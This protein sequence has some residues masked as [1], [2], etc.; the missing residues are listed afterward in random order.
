[1]TRQYGPGDDASR[2]ER[3]ASLL[4]ETS[5]KVTGSDETSEND[6]L[7]SRDAARVLLGRLLFAL[8][9][10][11]HEAVR[12]AARD[13]A[14]FD[15]VLLRTPQ[16]PG[17][18]LVRFQ[19]IVRGRG[20]LTLPDRA[21]QRKVGLVDQMSQFSSHDLLRQWDDL[22][23]GTAQ[24]MLDELDRGRHFDTLLALPQEPEDE[25]VSL[26]RPQLAE[27][28]ER[29][30]EQ[31]GGRIEDYVS[32]LLDLRV[33]D[34][35]VGS[36]QRLRT[37]A[38]EI[39]LEV[40]YVGVTGQRRPPHCY[41]AKVLDTL[42]RTRQQ[43]TPAQLDAFEASLAPALADV[44]H[45]C[46]FGVGPENIHTKLSK[47]SYWLD[48][49]YLSRSELTRYADLFCLDVNILWGILDERLDWPKALTIIADRL[50][51]SFPDP[52]TVLFGRHESLYDKNSYVAELHERVRRPAEELLEWMW[53]ATEEDGERAIKMLPGLRQSLVDDARKVQAT[54]DWVYAWAHLLEDYDVTSAG[55]GGWSKLVEELRH[56]G[57]QGD[58]GGHEA[59]VRQMMLCPL[60]ESPEAIVRL[61]EAIVQLAKKRATAPGRQAPVL[62]RELA[63]PQ[64][65]PIG[66]HRGFDVVFKG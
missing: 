35:R 37:V 41:G 27:L 54:Y 2:I 39:A 23:A 48:G 61:R 11:R 29:C 45:R 8:A 59:L 26:V 40:S 65:F 43:V 13:N 4:E 31:S 14:R 19:N 53:G 34:G 49:L 55:R 60:K 33:L 58:D 22:I 42:E 21:L 20:P 17:E 16:R 44:M 12:Q 1:M 15:S 36:S 64:V 51:T 52:A 6:E 5:R 3:L 46:C 57:S 62:F 50:G 10:E 25:V 56:H 9:T 38:R 7:L 18:L 30:W 66:N 32:G 24:E 28:F 63:F 47:V